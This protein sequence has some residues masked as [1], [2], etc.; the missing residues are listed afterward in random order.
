MR[1]FSKDSI[2]GILQALSKYSAVNKFKTSSHYL[3][4]QT[5]IEGA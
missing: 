5:V 3:V 4:N 1:W 2:S